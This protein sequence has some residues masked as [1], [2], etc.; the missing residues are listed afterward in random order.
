VGIVVT[1]VDGIYH[2]FWE[3]V[4]LL[5]NYVTSQEN[6]ATGEGNYTITIDTNSPAL[7]IIYP[8]NL[9]NYSYNVS[10]L[11]YTISGNSQACW[12]SVDGGITNVSLT[13]GD[14]VT[15]L[16]SIEGSNSWTVYANDSAGN[17]NLSSVTFFK[18]IISPLF[19]N[20][21]DN[22]DNL[23]D[24][25][26]GLFNVTI[27]NTNG[28]VWLTIN[29]V[30]VT[31]TNLT[32]NVYNASYNFASSGVY[33]YRWFAYGNGSL[34]NTNNSGARS[35]TV[36]GVTEYCGDGT[37][38]NG[39]TCSSCA[40]DCGACSG[41]GCTST[42]CANVNTITC[43]SSYVDNCG[44]SCGTGTKCSS[45]FNCVSGSCVLSCSNECALTGIKQCSGS[46]YQTCGN[47]DAD[48]CLEWSS[49]TSCSAGQTCSNGI[50][51]IE[52][53]NECVPACSTGFNCVSGSC[54]EGEHPAENIIPINLPSIGGSGGSCVKNF[55]CGEWSKCNVQYDVSVLLAG[56]VLSG[57]R[58]RT[59]TDKNKCLAN[60]LQTEI[61][62]IKEEIEVKKTQ[63]CGQ[64]Y[65]EIIS[66]TSG[67][68]L[69]RIK[70]LSNGKSV[71][72]SFNAIGEGT[73]PYCYDGIK[74]YDEE[75]TDCGGS[76]LACGES[77]PL[78]TYSIIGT[79]YGYLIPFLVFLI[80]GIMFAYTIRF[81]MEYN[82][83]SGKDS[84]LRRYNLWKKQGYDVNVL[85]E[86]MTFMNGRK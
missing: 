18:D 8:Q 50:C 84:F 23:T 58:T 17:I 12:Y 6:L 65:T 66:R 54:V 48:S 3:V 76:C 11:N 80:F 37:C 61:C 56:G 36:L 31:A 73:C 19:F 10:E 14:N 57:E 21:Y 47:Y 22:T 68:I 27:N 25:G 63:W 75:Q 16:T 30:N 79:I 1:L 51:Q 45:G 28:T 83:K 34:N 60:F 29:N 15:G 72:L 44:T 74:N 26:V 49:V 5:N 69:A 39:E 42:G 9:M 43:G 46:G 7:N 13:C 70:Q 71:D 40:G 55:I 78:R 4:D 82:R 81:M 33:S 41:G 64:Q 32:E 35:Y 62:Q 2:W 53:S 77:K 85:D 20:Y 52:E 38:N 24:S 86:D 67:K 59:C